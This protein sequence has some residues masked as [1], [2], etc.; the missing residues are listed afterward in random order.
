[1]HDLAL[2]KMTVARFVGKWSILIRYS[3]NGHTK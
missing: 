2:I 3:K 1:M